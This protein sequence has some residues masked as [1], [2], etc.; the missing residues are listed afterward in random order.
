MRQETRRVTLTKAERDSGVGQKL[1]GLLLDLS[2]DGQVTR[3]EMNRLRH[4]LELDRGVEFPACAFLYEIIDTIAADGE[5]TDAELDRLMLSVERV[6]PNDAR[7]IAREKRKQHREARRVANAAR[8]EAA[9]AQNPTRKRPPTENV[10][11]CF[12]A[13]TSSLPAS[14]IQSAAKPASCSRLVTRSSS[15]E[16]RTIDTTKTRFFVLATDGSELGYVP[17][18]DAR[19]MAPLLDAGAVCE[20]KI[21]KLLHTQDEMVLPVVVPLI[22]RDHAEGIDQPH[23]SETPAMPRPAAAAAQESRE[24][25][26]R[27]GC[28]AALGAMIAA[29]LLALAA[30]TQLLP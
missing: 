25:K 1:I 26:A 14:V 15:S 28:L 21:K 6:L 18:G 16:N 23:V 2:E 24:P 17:R 13:A 5:I 11:E 4:W 3:D 10:G 9:R 30:A 7:S 12:T 19:E 29:S 27:R 20:A 22:R 8:R